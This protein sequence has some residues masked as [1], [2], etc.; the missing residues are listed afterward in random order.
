[1]QSYELHYMNFV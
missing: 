1:M